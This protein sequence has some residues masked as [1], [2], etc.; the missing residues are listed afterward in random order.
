METAGRCTARCVCVCAWM[1][2]QMDRQTDKQTDGW[3]DEGNVFSA[4]ER[5]R[6]CQTKEKDT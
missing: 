3:I 4:L 1:E 5:E 6:E 2:G